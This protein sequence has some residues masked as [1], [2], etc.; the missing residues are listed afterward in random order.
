MKQ[1]QRMIAKTKGKENHRDK[2]GPVTK[3][4]NVRGQQK[5]N[6]KRIRRE[7]FQKVLN[8]MAKIFTKAKCTPYHCDMSYIQAFNQQFWQHMKTIDEPKWKN[9]SWCHKH[10][11]VKSECPNIF[12]NRKVE[13]A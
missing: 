13:S 6:N 4:R 7:G 1:P 3:N 2:F 12:V 8:A 9:C 10:G 5:V 11:Y